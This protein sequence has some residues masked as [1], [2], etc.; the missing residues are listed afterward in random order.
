[1]SHKS[2]WSRGR[3]GVDGASDDVLKFATE[4]SDFLRDKISEGAVFGDNVVGVEGAADGGVLGSDGSDLKV[5]NGEGA[6]DNDSVGNFRI[7][8][9]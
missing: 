3:G 7:R 5:G 4:S 6:T 1:M 9:D 8:C 2:G